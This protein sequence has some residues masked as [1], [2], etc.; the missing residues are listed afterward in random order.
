MALSHKSAEM[1]LDMVSAIDKSS[2]SCF[3]SEEIEFILY[4]LSTTRYTLN[5][6]FFSCQLFC[7]LQLNHIFAN[8]SKF[9]AHFASIQP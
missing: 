7:G 1:E 9:H 3:I 5:N 8:L 2:G 4:Q 6:P